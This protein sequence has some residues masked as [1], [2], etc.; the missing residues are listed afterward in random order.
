MTKTARCGRYSDI[1][2]QKTNLKNALKFFNLSKILILDTK[3]R[4]REG[5][6]KDLKEIRWRSTDFVN[7]IS[8]NGQ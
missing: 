7:I 1:E 4:E 3:Q 6:D 2:T 5:G 8:S